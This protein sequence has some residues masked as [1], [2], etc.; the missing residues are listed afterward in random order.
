MISV[1]GD[2]YVDIVFRPVEELP[3]EGGELIVESYDIRAGGSAGYVAQALAMLGMDVEV[4]TAIGDGYLSDIWK[5]TMRSNLVDVDSVSTIDSSTI[6]TS[7]VLLND[8]DR[9][10]ITYRGANEKTEFS[11]EDPGSVLMISGFS[12]TPALWTNKFIDLIKHQSESGT[13]IT[14]DTN[15]SPGEWHPY[16]RDILPHVDYLLIND[17]EALKF[18][19]SSCLETAISDL[20]DFGVSTC[21]ISQGENGCIAAVEEQT[22]RFPAV[23]TDPIDLNAAGDIFNAAFISALESG[24]EIDKACEFANESAAATISVFPMETKLKRLNAKKL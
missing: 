24:Y 3:P 2:A 11:I 22:E 8:N 1:I 20:L 14:L 9:R 21:I 16:A 13:T 7:F 15:W 19:E 23:E 4:Q 18:T 6:G 5:S 10:F 12:Q 17:E